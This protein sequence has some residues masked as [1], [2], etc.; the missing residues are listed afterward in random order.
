MTQRAEKRKGFETRTRVTPRRWR[1]PRVPI[2]KEREK[3][4][5]GQTHQPR[6]RGGEKEERERTIRVRGTDETVGRDQK[7]L[8]DDPAREK[9]EKRHDKKTRQLRVHGRKEEM[10]GTGEK[11]N[12]ERRRTR[13]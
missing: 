12:Q 13:S 3:R 9:Q 4:S 5:D 8:R 1:I 7:T 2:R 11:M 6:A 10:E